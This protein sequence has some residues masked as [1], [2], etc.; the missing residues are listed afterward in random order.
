MAHG[1]ARFGLG[2]VL[3]LVGALVL[4]GLA[5]G[6]ALP[7]GRLVIGI[8]ILLIGARMMVRAWRARGVIATSG[9]AVLGDLSFSQSDVLDH[10]ERFDIVLGR[11]TIDL[12]NVVEPDH[13]VT[14]TIETLLGRTLV[15]LPPQ[16]A[17]DIEGTAAFGQVRLPDR[18]SAATVRSRLHLRLHAVLGVCQVVEVPAA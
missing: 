15:K 17:C 8:G 9:E 6:I 5:T 13:D 11:G 18:T 3:A 4:V 14:V 12:T 16:I 10:D 2:F 7:I 1:G